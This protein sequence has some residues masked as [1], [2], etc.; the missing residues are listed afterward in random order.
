MN[1]REKREEKSKLIIEAYEKILF[2]NRCHERKLL[3]MARDKEI[4]KNRP[5][6]DHWY[7][8]KSGEFNQ[9]FYRNRV[10][11]KPN[12]ENLMYLQRL[13]DDKIY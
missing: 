10:A 8:M 12:N 3:N 13:R 1:P 2:D 9:E 6:R 5:P 7:E 11:L 4:Q